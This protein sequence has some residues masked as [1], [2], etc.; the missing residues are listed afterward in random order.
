MK[1]KL[2]KLIPLLLI[3]SSCGVISSGDMT[4]KKGRLSFFSSLG[5]STETAL[6]VEKK[7]I[8]ME[9]DKNGKFIHINKNPKLNKYLEDNL[10]MKM[11]EQKCNKDLYITVGDYMQHMENRCGSIFLLEYRLKL[12]GEWDKILKND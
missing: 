1:L 10:C 2:L 12:W 3:L 9:L 11:Y 7:F 6:C 5:A 8:S 4:T